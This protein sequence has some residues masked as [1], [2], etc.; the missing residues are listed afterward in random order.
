MTQLADY[1]S[2]EFRL[3]KRGK[4]GKSLRETLETV[5]RMT[6]RMPEEGINPVE[7]PE[8][9]A[10]LWGWFLRLNAGRGGGFGTQ[11]ITEQGIGWFF[12]NRGIRPQMWQ[13][14]ALR[15]LDRVALD[16]SSAS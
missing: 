14:D 2:H 1:A 5:A 7:F 16:S 10:E 13:L 3:N 12:H 8:V 11:P 15:L 9:L 4:D 6:G